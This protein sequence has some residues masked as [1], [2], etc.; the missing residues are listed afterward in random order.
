M[1][2][3]EEAMHDGPSAMCIFSIL[4][5][6]FCI[7]LNFYNHKIML[8]FLARIKICSMEL[9]VNAQSLEFIFSWTLLQKEAAQLDTHQVLFRLSLQYQAILLGYGN[10]PSHSENASPLFTSFL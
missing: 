7:F 1:W 9:Q 10:S 4:Q 2:S 8:K 5:T 6:I 3:S